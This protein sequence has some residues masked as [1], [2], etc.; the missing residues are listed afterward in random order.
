MFWG[1][2]GLLGGHAGAILGPG[3]P[4]VSAGIE[5]ERKSEKRDFEDPPPG[6]QFGDGN[7]LK[8]DP[9]PSV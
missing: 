1:V 9:G 6:L 7:Q 2:L 5:K 8:V 4:K 3:G